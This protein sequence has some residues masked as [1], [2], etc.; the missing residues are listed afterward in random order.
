MPIVRV[1]DIE[2]DVDVVVFDKDGTL[3]DLDAPWGPV[4]H[5]RVGAVA[6]DDVGLMRYLAEGLSPSAMTRRRLR[7]RMRPCRAS[8]RS[9]SAE[10]VGDRP[11]FAAR[12]VERQLERRCW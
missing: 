6:G 5:S 1:S 7:D 11:R 2:F 10:Q 8:T 3:I 4:A 9:G 12:M